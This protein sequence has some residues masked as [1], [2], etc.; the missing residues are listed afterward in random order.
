MNITQ[1]ENGMVMKAQYGF[2]AWYKA[3]LSTNIYDPELLEEL[4]T[5]KEFFKGL[6]SI[7]YRNMLEINKE[8]AVNIIIDRQK[9]SAEVTIENSKKIVYEFLSKLEDN[10]QLL[11]V[12]FI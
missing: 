6:A 5:N 3:N 4:N 2:E 9:I 8:L 12:K 7:F 11:C 1:L 10:N